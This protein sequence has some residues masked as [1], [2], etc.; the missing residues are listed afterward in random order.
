MRAI[1]RLLYGSG[2]KTSSTRAT[3]PVVV[4]QA[5]SSSLQSTGGGN[6]YWPLVAAWFLGGHYSHYLAE[7][8]AKDL[9]RE[10]TKREAARYDAEHGKELQHEAMYSTN[11]K[12]IYEADVWNA[13]SSVC[14][15]TD[16]GGDDD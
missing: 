13:S 15:S 6:G 16:F 12:G 4:T 10:E 11:E 2:A 1:K 9:R 3:S 7:E 5:K 8:H 14:D